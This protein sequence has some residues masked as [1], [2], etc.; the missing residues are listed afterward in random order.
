MKQLKRVLVLFHLKAVVIITLYFMPS[1][2]RRAIRNLQDLA[3]PL[4]TT[5]ATKGRK[6]LASER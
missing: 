1:P 2:I 6:R 3:N 5:A 4:Q